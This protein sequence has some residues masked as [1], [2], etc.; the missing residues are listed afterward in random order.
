M[1]GQ[2]RDGHLQDADV[3]LGGGGTSLHGV[4][5][6][7]EPALPGRSS[8]ARASPPA[9]SGRSRKASN[10]WNPNVR[11][12][13]AAAF[14]FSL[15]AMVIV[16]SKSMHSSSLRS[17]PAPAAHACA[18]A[19]ARAWRTIGRWS[20]ST[21]S[22]A[23]HAVGIEAT[24]PN[25]S[26]RSPRTSMTVTASAPSA[27]ATARSV[28]TRPGACRHGP[29]Y[30]STRAAFSSLNRPVSHASYR[31]IPSPACETTLP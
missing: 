3:I 24:D 7:V 22:S 19:S 8:P 27:T 15:C 30:V 12:H 29:R 26:S 25:A 4:L 18:R 1:L 9:I 13:V 5:G 28:S 11:F 10:G 31:S 2:C 14:S 21:R 23:R 17:G 16:A 20:A 6:G